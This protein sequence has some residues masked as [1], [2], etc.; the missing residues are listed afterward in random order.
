MMG[1]REAEITSESGT[2][3]AILTFAPLSKSSLTASVLALPAAQIKGVPASLGASML[4]PLSNKASTSFKQAAAI[5][6][7]GLDGG[8]SLA[9]AGVKR[10]RCYQYTC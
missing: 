8:A 4:K 2:N 1:A 3:D 10:G 7:R 6:E 5:G 9:G